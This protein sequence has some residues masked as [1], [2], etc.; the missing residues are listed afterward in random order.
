VRH[1]V[2]VVLERQYLDVVGDVRQSDR[3]SGGQ[4]VDHVVGEGTAGAVGGGLGSH[5]AALAVADQHDRVAGGRAR[6]GER[7]RDAAL[8]SGGN[9]DHSRSVADGAWTAG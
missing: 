4:H 1:D 5:H 2:V 9:P 6:Q 7:F 8:T 3:R